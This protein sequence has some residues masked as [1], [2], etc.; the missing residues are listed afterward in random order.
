MAFNSFIQAKS[1]TC[2]RIYRHIY[3]AGYAQKKRNKNTGRVCKAVP[4]KAEPNSQ[5]FTLLS[6]CIHLE[7][8]LRY[9]ASSEHIAV[10]PNAGLLFISEV[11]WSMANGM[12]E[13]KKKHCE[14]VPR[15]LSC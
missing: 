5:S 13:Q 4:V 10:K 11:G 15:T 7:T 6:A 3:K 12:H 14:F 8:H 9:N 2:H 1:Q